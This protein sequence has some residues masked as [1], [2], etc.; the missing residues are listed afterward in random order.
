MAGKSGT[1]WALFKQSWS[2]LRLDKELLLFPIFSSIACC[3][4]MLTFVV[5]FAVIPVL[6]GLVQQGMNQNDANHIVIKA[7][8][9]VILFVFYVA[10]YTVIVFFNTALVSCAIIRFRGG[11]PNVGDGLRASIK[12]LP[13]ILS[14][15]ILSATVGLILQQIESQSRIVGQIVARFLGLA[16]TITTYFVVPV[17]AVEN[18]GP[19][20]AVKRSVSLL[21]KSWGEG[22]VGNFSLKLAGFLLALPGIVVMVGGIIAGVQA[23]SAITA[24]IIAGVGVLYLTGLCIV[25]SSV[26]QV[27]LAG[28]Y[29]YAAEETTP[30]GFDESSLR[31]AFQPK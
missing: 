3:L 27:F 5:P 22:L 1:G 7:I 16:W 20:A 14:W 23:E 18:L 12:R 15:A 25:M 4:V 24:A 19:F 13:Q 31:L 8:A 28:L 9:L 26:K 17:V 11:D 21:Q 6:N 2:V 10:N 29:L 30:P